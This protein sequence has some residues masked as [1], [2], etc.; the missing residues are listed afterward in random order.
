MNKIYE[1]YITPEEYEIAKE[2]GICRRL[3][4]SRVRELG[5]DKKTAISKKPKYNKELRKYIKMAEINGIKESTFLNR[6]R[7]LKW[8]LERAATV[9]VKSRKQCVGEIAG[10]NRKYS[11]EVYEILDRNGINR[12]TFR[13]RI[14]KG[15][16]L[17][18]ACTR[19]PMTQV[20]ISKLGNK[21]YREKYGHSFGFDLGMKIKA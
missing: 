19:K 11:K 17:E 13:I 16:S 18:E 1:Y 21:R 14:K 20:E 7:K 6:V 8:E 3:L 5:W 2:N 4:D 9:P 12:E 10:H 15:W